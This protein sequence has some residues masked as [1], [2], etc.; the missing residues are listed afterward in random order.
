LT[1]GSAFSYDDHVPAKEVLMRILARPTALAVAVLVVFAFLLA[2]TVAVQVKTTSVRKD[3]KFTSAA[4]AAIRAGDTLEK[5]A[6]QSGWVKVRTKSGVVGWVHSTAV[7]AKKVSL[8]ASGKTMQTQA[9]AGE[10]ALAAK[11]F[12]KQVEDAYRSANPNLDFAGVDR[13]EKIRPTAAEIEA[14]LKAGRLGE[15]GGAQ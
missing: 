6:T 14:F 7:T 4:V 13:L 15:S 2:E 11:G 1:C 5:L 9:S 12:N 3:P 10:V 8:T